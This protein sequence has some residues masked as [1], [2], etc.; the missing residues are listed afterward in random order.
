MTPFDL[1]GKVAV[2]TGG[3]GGIGLAIAR[4]LA[5]AGAS[6]VV[7][8]RNAAKNASAVQELSALGRTAHA[9]VV[10]L[11]VADGCREAIASAAAIHGRLDV[12]AN[13]AGTNIRKPPQDYSLQEW[14]AVIDTNLSGVFV[15][16]QAAY[17]HLKAAAHGKIVNVGE[18]FDDGSIRLARDVPVRSPTWKRCMR[19]TT[20]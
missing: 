6:L 12:L 19:T 15:C 10:D 9:L 16:C 7:V 18:T 2:V 8:G 14:Q 20:R 11:S 17:P 13:N 1:T 5:R 3:N 4:G